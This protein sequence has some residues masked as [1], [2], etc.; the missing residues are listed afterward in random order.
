MLVLHVLWAW[1]KRTALVSHERGADAQ[2][3]EQPPLKKHCGGGGARRAWI[4][5]WSTRS[6]GRPNFT[7]AKLECAQ[8]TPAEKQHLAE[9]GRVA[10]ANHRE[11]APAFAPT[12]WEVIKKL[13]QEGRGWIHNIGA[14]QPLLADQPWTPLH[15]G[16]F[17]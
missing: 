14:P 13:S 15:G 17:M 2:V 11:G 16:Q 9:L 4:H 12:H 8:L 5:L 7:L 3:S 10:S 1:S 6:S